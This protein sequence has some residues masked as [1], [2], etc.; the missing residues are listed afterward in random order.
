MTPPRKRI[1]LE[2]IP[3]KDRVKMFRSSELASVLSAV[4][5]TMFVA[6][7]GSFIIFLFG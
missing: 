5:F 3:L 6:A 2:R 1:Y 7:S 4:I